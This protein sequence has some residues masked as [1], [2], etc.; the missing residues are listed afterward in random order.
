[1]LYSDFHSPSPAIPLSSFQLLLS[2][3]LLISL[4]FLKRYTLS[5]LPLPFKPQSFTKMEG[6]QHS[7]NF[8]ERSK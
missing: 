2:H 3:E 1:M 8:P 6:N 5:F 4:L 7:K